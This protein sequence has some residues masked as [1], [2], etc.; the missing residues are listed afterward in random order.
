M[1]FLAVGALA[2]IGWVASN[3]GTFEQ[4]PGRPREYT[5]M[6]D[7]PDPLPDIES[8]YKTNAEN[9]ER[10][11]HTY[12]G[13]PPCETGTLRDLF[14]VR[15]YGDTG[16]CFGPQDVT[17]IMN[18]DGLY[19]WYGRGPKVPMTI[20]PQDSCE[21]K[22]PK[23]TVSFSDLHMIPVPRDQPFGNTPTTGLAREHIMLGNEARGA[24]F[25]D[26][27]PQHLD[28]S[29]NSDYGFA[30]GEM[31]T[32]RRQ[33]GFHYGRERLFREEQPNRRQQLYFRLGN[34]ESTLGEMRGE[35]GFV[36]EPFNANIKEYY[37]PPM[38]NAGVVANRVRADQDVVLQCTTRPDQ[39]I[40]WAGPAGS[41]TGQQE[42]LRVLPGYQDVNPNKTTQS[43]LWGFS[44]GVTAMR[45]PQDSNQVTNLRGTHREC[46]VQNDNLYSN[47]APHSTLTNGS[48]AALNSEYYATN[49]TMRSLTDGPNVMRP[50]APS[51]HRDAIADVYN[52]S[53]P[54][55]SVDGYLG[56]NS[57]IN[58]TN[59]R[60]TQKSENINFNADGERLVNSD[61]YMG[62]QYGN[63]PVPDTNS[64]S[65]I[66]QLEI[67]PAL[68]DA[69]RSNPY[70]QPLP[71]GCTPC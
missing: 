23:Q 71:P 69:F 51:A 57:R 41:V 43:S 61:R 29:C 5:G 44:K 21:F 46:F 62:P 38:P 14:S 3:L 33:P 27:Y 28:P 1:E 56:D 32:K 36:E 10:D 16:N 25:N 68:L 6:G 20:D 67:D 22:P 31:M 54:G 15:G 18:P 40:S 49:Q 24:L 37:R 13:P 17:N 42:S 63:F 7:A 64:V 26:Y 2:G 35:L 9:D 12:P 45:G 4:T 65:S 70:A 66:I 52:C 48:N 53:N 58:P 50:G 60:H 59:L 39:Y 55:Q 11:P 30:S 47:P 19:P 8:D 34:K